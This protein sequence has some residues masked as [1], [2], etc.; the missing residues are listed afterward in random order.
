[1]PR[2]DAE[3]LAAYKGQWV[4]VDVPKGMSNLG[5]GY[6]DGFRFGGF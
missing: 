3:R 4:R 1:M 6:L 5:V 2:L